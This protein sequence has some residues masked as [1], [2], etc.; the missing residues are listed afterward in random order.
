M[1]WVTRSDLLTVAVTCVYFGHPPPRLGQGTCW[2][3]STAAALLPS[4]YSRKHLLRA[5]P[6]SS[7]AAVVYCQCILV[8]CIQPHTRL[9]PSCLVTQCVNVNSGW[10]ASW[11]VP[12]IR[13]PFR[14]QSDSARRWPIVGGL[15]AT[16]FYSL[17]TFKV[18]CAV[19][20]KADWCTCG[21]RRIVGRDMLWI[22]SCRHLV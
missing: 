7:L 3:I 17:K 9:S 15:I 22:C 16:F 4:E 11:L 10:S 18:L 19:S 14:P 20:W 1:V 8:A 21:S 2:T 5:E 6:G 13:S 12:G